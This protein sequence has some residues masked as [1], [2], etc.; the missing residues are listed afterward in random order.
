MR[1]EPVA[2][3]ELDALRRAEIERREQR[4]RARE[5]GA[6]APL[7]L[8]RRFA[9]SDARLVR[10]TTVPKAPAP[11]PLRLPPRVV[12]VLQRV[13]AELGEDSSLPDLMA[14]RAADSTSPLLAMALQSV[15]LVSRAEAMTGLGHL[16]DLAA[17]GLPVLTAEDRSRAEALRAGRLPLP[18]TDPETVDAWQLCLELN[19]ARGR[20][21]LSTAAW[22]RLVRELPLPVLDDLIDSG[23]L[24]KAPAPHSWPERTERVTYVIA[25]LDPRHLSD[26]DVQA[27]GWRDE[28]CRR[29]LEAGGT[30][31]PVDGRYDE[32]SLRSALLGGDLSALEAVGARNSSLP[33]DLS[34]L[35]LALRQLRQGGNVTSALGRDRSLFGLLEDC[36]SNDRLVSGTTPFHYWAGTRRLYR[37]LDDMHWAMACEP[38]RTERAVRSVLQ[39]AAALRSHESRGP[40]GAADREA[41]AVQAYVGFLHARP[42]DRDRLDQGV[43]LLEDV[44]KRGGRRRGGVGG[45]LRHRMRTLSELLQSLRQK[46]KPHDVLNPY[47]ALCVEHGSTEWGQGWRDLRRQVAAD[48]LEYIN[49]AKDRIRR[50]ET[51]RRLGHE[52]ET[53]YEL[54]L[55]ERFLWVPDDRSE[56][57]QP[58]PRPLGR[59]TAPSS[60]EEKSWAA[61]Q[62]A[63]EI[64]GRCAARLRNHH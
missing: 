30:I 36:L 6:A 17:G 21:V 53:L 54:P 8:S 18:D 24:G 40:A 2:S 35:V 39:Q 10:E 61:A 52:G 25:R 50:L 5:A 64:I 22:Q 9:D 55:D 7:R 19:E 41:R 20:A 47:L 56:L 34:D 49:G 32:W 27:L 58:G 3:D 42:G 26:D 12:H 51:A 48:Q 37:L 46:G 11:Q 1:T 29:T 62:A 38:D 33:T 15:E 43:G 57:L 60:D 31:D 28:A 16:L 23:A 45:Q 13:A 4:R 44:L 63:S 14:E 59:R